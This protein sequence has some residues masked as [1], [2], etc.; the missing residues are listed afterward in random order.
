MSRAR[1]SSTADLGRQD[2]MLAA[3]R[4]ARPRHRCAYRRR[5]SKARSPGPLSCIMR[6]PVDHRATSPV[7]ALTCGRRSWSDFRCHR[8]RGRDD[9]DHRVRLHPAWIKGGDGVTGSGKNIPR[10]S[11]AVPSRTG[12]FSCCC[13]AASAARLAR[14]RRRQ[15]AGIGRC[16]ALQKSRGR[17]RLGTQP[18]AEVFERSD[19]SVLWAS[20]DDLQKPHRRLQR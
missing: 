18:I 11:H 20:L 16:F 9:R 8:A 10:K 5:S 2:R 7:R 3:I 19:I 17:D 13:P 15:G 4:R 1:S 12:C 14:P 6:A